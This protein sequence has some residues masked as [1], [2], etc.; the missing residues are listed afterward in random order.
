V[1]REPVRTRTRHAEPPLVRL[2]EDETERVQARDLVRTLGEVEREVVAEVQ[3]V[4]L[5][6]QRPA[7]NAQAGIQDIARVPWD[8]LD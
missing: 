4:D 3:S 2:S 5:E 7:P 8:R 6:R 1:P